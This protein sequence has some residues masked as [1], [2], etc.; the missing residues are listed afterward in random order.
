MNTYNDTTN[1][2]GDVVALLNTSGTAVVTYT[3]D[4][5]GKLLTTGG[6]MATTLGALNPIRYRGYV[7]DTETGLYYVSSR[8]Y[9]PALARFINA[10]VLVST[11]QGIL[12]NNMFAYCL[13]SPI[14]R[15]DVLGN[16]SV[17]IFDEDGN[18]A[19]DDDLRFNG[20]RMGDGN[21]GGKISNGNSG[22]KVSNSN[23]GGKTGNSSAGTNSAGSGK[24]SFKSEAI[25]KEHYDR[26]NPEFGNAFSNPQEYLD[27]ANYVIENGEYIPN[28]NAYVKFYGMGGGANYA[29]V[30]LSHDGLFI[31]T[32]HIKYVSR[33][34]WI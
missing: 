9:D 7:Y 12:G 18:P 24:L 29:F 26:H 22:G 5:W 16:T 32:F 13:N 30:G 2:Q 31:T 10:D 3:Y 19:T 25:L 11:G 27:A 34:L 8:Y 15:K 23:A 21:T 14:L 17:D 4:A 6:S 28:Q 33:I 20:G 1:L